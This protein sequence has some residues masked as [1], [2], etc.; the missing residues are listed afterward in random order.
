MAQRV[1]TN[2]YT[3]AINT[4]IKTQNISITVGWAHLVQESDK[5]EWVWGSMRERDQTKVKL[6]DW[7][8]QGGLGGGV[9]QEINSSRKSNFCGKLTN[10]FTFIY[11]MTEL[12]DQNKNWYLGSYM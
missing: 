8:V 12:T 5:N 2:E 3:L 7:G 4:S 11:I 1:M 9:L 6:E 10:K